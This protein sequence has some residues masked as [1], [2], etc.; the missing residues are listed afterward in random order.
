MKCQN[1]G[2]NNQPNDTT[3]SRC[4]QP[5]SAS[6]EQMD[7]DALYAPSVSLVGEEGKTALYVPTEEKSRDNSSISPDVSKTVVKSVVPIAAAQTIVKA[8]QQDT[9]KVP[10]AADVSDVSKTIVKSVDP[11]AAAKTIVKAPVLETPAA[12][13][14]VNVPEP[15]ISAAPTVVA[16]VPIETANKTVCQ[17]LITCPH[18]GFYPVLSSSNLCPSCKKPLEEKEVIKEEV[19]EIPKE[20]PVSVENI[21]EKTENEQGVEPQGTICR[22]F[23]LSE[24]DDL[25]KTKKDTILPS[26]KL[27]LLPEEGEQIS[28]VTQQYDNGKAILNR[29][30]TEPGNMS[31]TSKEQ[32][33]VKY[34]DGSWYIENRSMAK[35][36]YIIVER[37]MEL[38]S[39]D[40]IILG[41]RRFRFDV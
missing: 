3:C 10:V 38:Q 6:I 7:I 22:P 30:N 13:T 41:N 12:P 33:E 1:C 23:Y 9:P 27:T 25:A 17:T 34:E 28:S 35:S 31:I 15:E 20:E 18:C 4:G 39:G 37:K 8:P 16:P 5:L 24:S 14:V 36:T 11:V 29:D 40:I 32:A 21:Y 26:F 19:K 2:H